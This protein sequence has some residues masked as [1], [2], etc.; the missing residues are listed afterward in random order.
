MPTLDKG[1][2]DR[3]EVNP[4]GP[5]PPVR[6]VSLPKAPAVT[7]ASSLAK[8]RLGWGVGAAP[9]GSNTESTSHS[10]AASVGVGKCKRHEESEVEEPLASMLSP[11][12]EVI[13][14]RWVI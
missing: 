7:T 12:P 2:A 10:S 6:E 13:M 11:D 3:D 9:A 14:E 4:S 1:W 5:K 8:R